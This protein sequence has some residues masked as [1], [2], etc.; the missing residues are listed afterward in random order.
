[1]D[2]LGGVFLQPSRVMTFQPCPVGCMCVSQLL[3][4]HPALNGLEPTPFAVDFA[5]RRRLPALLDFDIFPRAIETEARSMTLNGAWVD[6]DGAG[7]ST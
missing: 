7:R 3:A 2:R 5:I 6:A 1:M 4:T